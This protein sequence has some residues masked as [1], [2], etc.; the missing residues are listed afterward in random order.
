MI[1]KKRNIGII[2]IFCLFA[3]PMY[4]VSEL[5]STQTFNSVEGENNNMVVEEPLIRTENR[6][7]RSRRYRQPPPPQVIYVQAAPAQNSVFQSNNAPV[8]S[9]I[10][11]EK[12]L[13]EKLQER[14]DNKL[15]QERLKTEAKILN[16]IESAMSES[17]AVSPELPQEVYPVNY[18]EVM[19]PEKLLVKKKLVSMYFGVGVPNISSDYY[20]IEGRMAWNLGL[21]Y[22]FNDRLLFTFGYTYARYDVPVSNSY[23]N[24]R[25]ST[26]NSLSARDEMEYNQN[27]FSLGTQIRLFHTESNLRPYVGGGVGHVRGYLNYKDDGYDSYRGNSNSDADYQVTSW[28]AFMRAGFDLKFSEGVGFGVDLTYN[29]ALSSNNNDRSYYGSSSR[30]KSRVGR[31]IYD[32]DFYVVSG[33]AFFAF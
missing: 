10:P 2:A 16:R 8:L 27:I 20:D 24:Y 26:R 12:S 19:E 30:D 7:Y 6:D 23:G 29:T 17:E 32:E 18:A 25:V 9:V 14:I 13:G 11:K 4:G 28:T 15:N 33:G 21:N 3:F 5:K 31:S 1:K 22:E